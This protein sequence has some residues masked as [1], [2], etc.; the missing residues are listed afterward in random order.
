MLQDQ[1]SVDRIGQLLVDILPALQCLHSQGQIHGDITPEHIYWNGNL[2][3]YQLRSNT[4]SL[5]NPVYSA[6][7]QLQGNPT[8]SSDLYSLGITCIHLLTGVHP[9][10]LFDISTEEWVWRDY[11]LPNATDQHGENIANIIDRLIQPSLEKRWHSA[12]EVIA[13]ITKV[14]KLKPV[15]YQLPSQWRCTQTLTGHQGIFAGITSL[16]ISDSHIASASED[17]TIRLWDLSTHQTRYI[18]KGHEGFVETVAFHPDGQILASGSRDRSVKLW[19]QDKLVRTLTEHTEPI[20]MVAFHPDG[21]VLASGSTDRTIKLWEVSTGKLLKTLTSHKLKVLAVAFSSLGTLAS[22]SADSTIVIWT[23]EA[24]PKQLTG[25]V[26]TVTT[27]AFS[28]DGQLLASGGEDRQIRLWD[29]KT[30]MCIRVLPGHPW[31]VSALAFSHDSKILFS[32]SWDR[33]VKVW[34]ISTGQVINTLIGHTDSITSVVVSTDGQQL[35]T[36]SRDRSVK[37]W[38][39]GNLNIFHN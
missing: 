15:T 39:Y 4:L 3:N 24:M 10:D 37:I 18:L 6:P 30:G 34:K 32:G 9:F 33:S 5:A 35:V 31:L 8:E 2:S 14:T 17:K 13:A 26:G 11:W 19:H 28:P 29:T 16:A 7:E 21:Q 12:A 22:A 36:G 20:N 25:H 1:I 27:I 23:D 38:Q